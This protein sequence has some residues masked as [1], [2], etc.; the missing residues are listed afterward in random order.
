MYA[1]TPPPSVSEQDAVV[2]DAGKELT[3]EEAMARGRALISKGQLAE[4]L[5]FLRQAGD[6]GDIEGSSSWWVVLLNL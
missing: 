1:Q 6:A 3:P 2:A 4:A 5:P